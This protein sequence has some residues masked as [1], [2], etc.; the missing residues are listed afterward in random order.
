[1]ARVTVAKWITHILAT[2]HYK[3]GC[4]ANEKEL[5]N[6]QFEI[7]QRE[8][9]RRAIPLIIFPDKKCASWEN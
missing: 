9:D 1:M 4:W 3:N 7:L 8:L 6:Q 2:L 5:I